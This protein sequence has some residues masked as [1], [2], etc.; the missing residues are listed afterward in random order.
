VSKSVAAVRLQAALAAGMTTFG[1]N[2]VQEAE[3]KVP[4]VSGARW[5]LVGHLQG[6]KVARAVRLF[7]SIDSVDS[8]DLARRLSELAHDLRDGRLMPI[9][10]QVNVDR[11]PAKE[12]FD[13]EG[14]ATTLSELLALPGL[15]VQGLMTVGRMV[16]R[17]EEARPTFATLRQLSERLR[18]V[19]PR[20]GPELSMGMS[21][22]FEV[23][24][25]EGATMV[26]VGRA[27]FGERTG[28]AG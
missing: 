27:L 25:E 26:R 12:G 20:L 17:A 23:A 9:L 4:D 13:P 3:S 14:L 7:D 10:L 24:V 6:N 5:R 21:D 1:E 19:E 28:P 22:D 18:R 8:L 11:D 16:D 15:E 2:R